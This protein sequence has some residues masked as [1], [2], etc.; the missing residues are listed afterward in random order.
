MTRI[1]L[2]DVEHL[3]RYCDVEELWQFFPKDYFHLVFVSNALDHTVHPIRSL[4][5]LLWVLHP[6]GKLML[7]HF[8]PWACETSC[9][10]MVWLFCLTKCCHVWPPLLWDVSF[11]I[12]VIGFISWVSFVILNVDLWH[13]VSNMCRN[14]HPEKW[15]SL[16]DG[17]HQW[18][19]DVDDDLK[20]CLPFHL[21]NWSHSRLFISHHSGPQLLVEIAEVD[22]ASSYGIIYIAGSSQFK[23]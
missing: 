11:S 2:Q 16:S 9:F 1:W 5:L 10:K 14:V 8:R 20:R 13:P 23:C 3:P 17:Q 18:G 21:V 22:K 7:R 6:D 19:F 4:K 12:C 15:T